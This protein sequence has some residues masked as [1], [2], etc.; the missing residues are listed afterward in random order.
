MVLAPNRLELG[1][2]CA[3]GFNST[4]RPLAVFGREAAFTSALALAR[5]SDGSNDSSRSGAN[6]RIHTAPPESA[7][8]ADFHVTTT[9]SPAM[10]TSRRAR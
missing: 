10:S 6:I 2:Q 5:S 3:Y 9:A 8:N 1:P 7:R 4:L